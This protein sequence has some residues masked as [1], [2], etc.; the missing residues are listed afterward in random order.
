MFHYFILLLFHYF[1]ETNSLSFWR[2]CICFA[3]STK[4]SVQCNKQRFWYQLRESIQG[5]DTKQTN[6]PQTPQKLQKT[7]KF[8]FGVLWL[9]WR[10]QCICYG[11]DT[12]D[13]V[14]KTAG[15]C[16]AD[17]EETACKWQKIISGHKT[18]GLTEIKAISDTSII[19]WRNW[20]P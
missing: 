10:K 16:C 6:K 11:V 18:P 5:V 7:F 17:T 9:F 3:H 15:F 20:T 1:P 2:T 14:L 4:I 8:I 12:V 19:H 13:K